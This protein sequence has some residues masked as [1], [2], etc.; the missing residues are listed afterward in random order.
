MPTLIERL[1]ISRRL[2]LISLSYTLPI[3]V[4]LY[5]VVHG[6]NQDI[7]FS[8]LE[9][10]GNAYQRP[11][12]QLL[13][14]VPK[15]TLAARRELTGDPSGRE[16]QVSSG[17]E[18]DRAFVALRSIDDR[19]AGDLQFTAEGL[20]ERGRSQIAPAAV[21]R[22]W[23]SLKQGGTAAAGT[24][25]ADTLLE[26]ILL[27][28]KHAGD[29][30]NL[31]LDP[32]L[33][34]YYLM[35]VTLLALPE[36]QRRY[37][38][39]LKSFETLSRQPTISPDDRVKLAVLAAQFTADLGRIAADI[40][41]VKVEDKNFYGVQDALQADLK[42]GFQRYEAAVQPMLQ[43]LA[44]FDVATAGENDAVTLKSLIQQTEVA[45]D[46]SFALWRDGVAWL[47]G[48]LDSRLDHLRSLRTWALSLAT[49]AWLASAGLVM[50]I[51]RSIAKPL[52]EFTGTLRAASDEVALAVEAIY[53]S[54]ETLAA[55]TQQQAASLQQA[56][57]SV[58]T[59]AGMTRQNAGDAGLANDRST[60][61]AEL[62]TRSKP[63]MVRMSDAMV[64]I[65]TSTD[66][67]TAVV[68]SITEIAFQTNLLALNAAVEAARA[69]QAG[70]GFAVVAEEVRSLAKRC[71]DSA[72]STNELI[73][74]VKD[75]TR[76]GLAVVDE[77]AGMLDG[78]TAS[79]QDAATLI[80]KVAVANS[81]QAEGIRQIHVS[82]GQLNEVTHSNATSAEQTAVATSQITAQTRE[83]TSLAEELSTMVR[84]PAAA[85]QFRNRAE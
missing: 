78:I 43:T 52:R 23:E 3:A 15:R 19:H 28:I 46:A 1:P 50:V 38:E 48:L 84:G 79:A 63:S 24:Q 20:A 51:T 75:S 17:A 45:R 42:P 69:G 65:K 44:R 54:S 6:I 55:S 21:Q 62:A 11:L 60:A 58:G 18:I 14:H 82:V 76:N 31:I 59:I 80:S 47:D 53:R 39:A 30:S 77:M 40:D 4:L 37:A 34:S 85:I 73:E 9:K 33:D 7:R 56:A 66:K 68:K 12:A 5:F 16:A 64:A 35:D 10:I 41:T 67:T 72:K 71:A 32:D 22:E 49:L 26:R 61:A 29:T 81:Q 8:E 25:A 70:Q 2:T 13:E 74:E 57:G 27:L 83:L 36:M